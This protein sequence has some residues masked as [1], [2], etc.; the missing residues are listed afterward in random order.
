MAFAY[1]GWIVATTLGNKIKNSKRNLP[2]ALTIAPLII[3][4]VYLL[5]FW[6]IIQLLGVEKVLAEG[7]NAVYA[8]GNLLLGTAGGKVI[9]TCVLI[10]LIGVLN[11]LVI[12][13]LRLPQL[14]LEKRMLGK[15]NFLLENTQNSKYEN[16]QKS[17]FSALVLKIALISTLMWISVHF[18][19]MKRDLFNGGDISEIAI[20]FSYV[21]YGLLYLRMFSLKA[22][23]QLT[24]RWLIPAL[25]LLGSVIIVAGSLLLNPLSV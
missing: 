17:A 18:V 7:K 9:L 3:L 20:V 16:E 19:V 22:I 11:G 23:P 6:G 4:V 8:A 13:L 14:L 15:F 2:L 25:A 21:A 5:Y 24:K 10:S 12:G 1:D